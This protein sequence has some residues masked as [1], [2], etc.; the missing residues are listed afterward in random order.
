MQEN[1]AVEKIIEEYGD[2]LY[3]L[4][5]I[6][7]CEAADAED[8]VQ[9]TVIAYFR[10][11]PEFKSTS[12][13]KAWLI[14]VARNKC[15][16]IMRF[17]KKHPVFSGEHSETVFQDVESTHIIE[18]LMEIPEKYRLVLTLHYIE[19]Y[20]VDEIAKIICRTPSAVKMRLS[21]GRELL[22]KKY[23]EDYL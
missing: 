8:A 5:L 4:C 2:M 12:H 23:K 1:S 6:M 13:E 16:S 14:T 11:A 7:L 10:K 20:K 17:K 21:K 9:E 15:R 18:A 19:G 22:E 3:R